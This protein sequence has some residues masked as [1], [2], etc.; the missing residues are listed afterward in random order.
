MRKLGKSIELMVWPLAAV[1]VFLAFQLIG[2]FVVSTVAFFSYGEDATAT[3]SVASWALAA[4]S[5]LTIVA[6]IGI[7]YFGLRLP[8]SLSGN[9]AV[10]VFVALLAFVFSLASATILNEL[11]D[12]MLDVRM[13]AEYAELF[14]NTVH[15]PVGLL[16][17]CLLGPI[18][19]ECVFRGGIMRPLLMRGV[20]PWIAILVSSVV[21]A[22]VHGNMVQIG[23]A[24]IMGLVLAVIYYRT[25]S[26]LVTSLCHVL[27]NTVTA[28]M[29]L[30]LPDYEDVTVG[31]MI[32][33][34][35]EIVVMLVAAALAFLLLKWLWRHTDDQFAET[36]Q[37]IFETD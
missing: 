35:L 18:A 21:F 6:M 12:E 4:S 1:L 5:L 14:K 11:A 7:R 32:G 34:P 28:V 16:A 29:M 36:L 30:T 15:H 33:R 19:E 17:L 23:Y 20:N 24:F 22:L 26:L 25:G 3:V 10:N 27:N 9:R 31:Q 8:L 13:P 2:S 37:H